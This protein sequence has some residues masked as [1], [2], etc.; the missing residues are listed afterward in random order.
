MDS[1]WGFT[2][3]LGI[4][5]GF[6][7]LLLDV[8]VDGT[9]GQ[10]GFQF[11]CTKWGFLIGLFFGAFIGVVI[12]PP[13]EKKKKENYEKAENSPY[14]G[15]AANLLHIGYKMHQASV[16]NRGGLYLIP[17]YQNRKFSGFT[18]LVTTF[19]KP[20]ANDETFMINFLI[21][22][23]MSGN[24]KT[25][26]DD[27]GDRIFK[28]DCDWGDMLCEWDYF[29]ECVWTKFKSKHPN[30]EILDSKNG[31]ISSVSLN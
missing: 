25:S 16:Y 22:N 30:C 10:G 31:G 15:I 24:W 20:I 18:V 2:V 13:N 28:V 12:A 19:E 5:F 4:G 26:T 3:A 6:I 7:G 14:S 11:T 29:R 17:K 27:Q 8:L 23:N 1:F 21:K 9:V